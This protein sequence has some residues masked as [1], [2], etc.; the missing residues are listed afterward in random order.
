MHGLL[1]LDD[2]VQSWIWMNFRDHQAMICFWHFE[3]QCAFVWQYINCV[4][5]CL[6]NWTALTSSLH[7][8]LVCLDGNIQTIQ[9]GIDVLFAWCLFLAVILT[10]DNYWFW[11]TTSNPLRF[12]IYLFLMMDNYFRSIKF[13]A[14]IHTFWWWMITSN[15]LMWGYSWTPKWSPKWSP[16]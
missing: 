6:C 13:F 9:F 5:Y 16:R 1:F 8:D 15:P 3:C 2:N 11:M 10:Y 12:C 14:F 4:K 7:S